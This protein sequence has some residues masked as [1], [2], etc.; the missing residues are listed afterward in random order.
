[1]PVVLLGCGLVL[2]RYHPL[3]RAV[4]SES[5]P[6]QGS[7]RGREAAAMP[8]WPW[9]ESSTT[10]DTVSAGNRPRPERRGDGTR[11]RDLPKCV[12]VLVQKKICMRLCTSTQ[13]NLCSCK[14]VYTAQG[15]QRFLQRNDHYLLQC[16]DPL[17]NLVKSISHKYA[18][19]LLMTS[20]GANIFVAAMHCAHLQRLSHVALHV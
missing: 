20:C 6:R 16:R 15:R 18:S 19:A 1:M 13:H 2:L 14:T 11:V 9:L 12:R 4:P 8:V 17:L 5:G 7:T 10:G 3:L